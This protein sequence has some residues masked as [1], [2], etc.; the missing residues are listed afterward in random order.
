MKTKVDF[1]VDNI[2]IV[3]VGYVRDSGLVDNLS[4]YFPDLE[5]GTRLP[6]KLVDQIKEEAEMLLIDKA[7][8]PEV[9][10]E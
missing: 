8:T 4:L 7:F 9:D 5:S 2:S 6:R 3:A 10:F 1:E